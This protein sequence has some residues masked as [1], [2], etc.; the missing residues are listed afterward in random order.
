MWFQ[1]VSLSRGRPCSMNVEKWPIREWRE[2]YHFYLFLSVQNW[3]PFHLGF[4]LKWVEKIFSISRLHNFENKVKIGKKMWYRSL[5]NT[6][7]YKCATFRS[8]SLG[9]FQKNTW[10]VVFITFIILFF[11]RYAPPYTTFIFVVL[12]HLQQSFKRTPPTTILNV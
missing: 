6:F 8:N 9:L 12:A 11:L 3:W 5:L 4:C 10:R 2:W 1:M 7:S